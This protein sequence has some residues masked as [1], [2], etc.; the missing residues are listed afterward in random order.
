MYL[1]LGFWQ[2]KGLGTNNACAIL[3]AARFDNQ[4]T[5]GMSQQHVGEQPFESSY[6]QGAVE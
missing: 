4:A 6:M 2:V 1:T 5:G 3:K